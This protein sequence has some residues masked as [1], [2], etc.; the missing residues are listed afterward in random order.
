MMDLHFKI[1]YDPDWIFEA[2]IHKFFYG[3]VTRQRT[4]HD[5]GMLVDRF[6]YHTS[7]LTLRHSL[8][9]Q[10]F[11]H[12]IVLASSGNNIVRVSN[13]YFLDK[14]EFGIGGIAG[15]PLAMSDM[16]LVGQ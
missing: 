6:Y 10:L 1:T 15:N 2:A 12:N 8:L 7:F 5:G 3:S 13:C 16:R 14:M 9:V 11:N 4:G